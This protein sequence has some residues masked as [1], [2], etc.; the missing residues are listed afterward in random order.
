MT[1]TYADTHTNFQMG[2]WKI[3]YQGFAGAVG[4]WR[5]RLRRTGLYSL[6][7][8]RPAEPAKRDVGSRPFG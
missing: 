6:R 8:P 2:L 1:Y 7:S 4:L 5:V 3:C